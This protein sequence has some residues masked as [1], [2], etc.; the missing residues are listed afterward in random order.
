MA[1]QL[2]KAGVNIDMA[3]DGNVGKRMKRANKIAA[4]AS[5]VIGDEELAA[6]NANVRLMAAG[7]QQTVALDNLQQFL[8][9]QSNADDLG[10]R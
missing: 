5:V 9:A 7:E 8:T 3:Y 10:A 4:W 6:G 2:R 1:H